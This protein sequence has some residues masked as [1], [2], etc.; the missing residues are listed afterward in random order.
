LRH[1]HPLAVLASNVDTI[2]ALDRIA[3]PDRN[4]CS[5]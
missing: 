3:F 5:A 4:C 1:A 2:W